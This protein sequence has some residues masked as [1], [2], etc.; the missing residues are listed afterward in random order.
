MDPNATILVV[1]DDPGHARLVEKN[2]RRSG[3]ANAIH[4]FGSGAEVLAFLASPQYSSQALVLLDL[5]MPGMHGQQVLARIKNDA[6]T[7]HL[8]VIVLT[9]AEDGAEMRRC[10]ELGCN[11]YLTKPVHYDDFVATVHKLGLFLSI[12]AIP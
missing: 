12:V 11:F 9:T 3:I 5:N 2:L 1:D 10:Y 8:P 4:R 7:R 6:H